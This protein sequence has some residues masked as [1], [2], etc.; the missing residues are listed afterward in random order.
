MKTECEKCQTKFNLPDAKLKPGVDFAFVCPK[1]KHKNTVRVPESR[2]GESPV[3][4]DYD[5]DDDDDVFSGDF[6][7][8]GARPALI[9][10]DP[11]PKRDH[12]AEIVEKIDFVPFCLPPWERPCKKLKITKFN[13]VLVDENFAGQSMRAMR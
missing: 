6:F 1:C 5:D 11:G 9:C 10:F 4:N 8:E 12:L 2:V 7:E 3:Y 13:L